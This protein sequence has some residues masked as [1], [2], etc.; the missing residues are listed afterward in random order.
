LPRGTEHSDHGF[1]PLCVLLDDFVNSGLEIAPPPPENSL[2]G[3]ALLRVGSRSG[4]SQEPEAA[5]DLFPSRLG[6]LHDPHLGSLLF[7]AHHLPPL[8]QG[9][10]DAVG[11]LRWEHPDPSQLPDEGGCPESTP[12]T[13]EIRHLAVVGV[14]D[15]A[16][17]APLLGMVPQ[18]LALQDI[19]QLPAE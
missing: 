18:K 2:R 1:Q 5:L 19:Q 8:Q 15:L 4:S 9:T 17:A 12:A 10:H 7:L 11:Q 16:S 6:R 3:V 13:G 14:L